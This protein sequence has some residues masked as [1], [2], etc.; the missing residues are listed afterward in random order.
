MA[1]AASPGARVGR[2]GRGRAAWE[3]ALPRDLAPPARPPASPAGR[4]PAP[5]HDK[6][7]H[8]SSEQGDEAYGPQRTGP[9]LQEPHAW[10]VGAGW[11][12]PTMRPS[13]FLLLGPNPAV[14]ERAP[15]R[16][17]AGAE[18]RLEVRVVGRWRM[19]CRK[20]LA[21]LGGRLRSALCR[22][23]VRLH[24]FSF[25]MGLHRPCC[26]RVGT[27]VREAS[28]R[29]TA[30]VNAER[31]GGNSQGAARDRGSQR[32]PR[33]ASGRISSA[34]RYFGRRS[35]IR[36]KAFPTANSVAAPHA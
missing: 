4:I 17:Q 14:I 6:P 21:R 10:K 22:E 33:R 13:T 5:G 35:G 32:G 19:G 36:P 3:T 9:C 27:R 30:E 8:R 20:A 24:F 34:G 11:W 18:E 15:K 28:A 12:A 26:L 31:D 25:R 1:S 29:R 16:A 23:S 2:G 7:P